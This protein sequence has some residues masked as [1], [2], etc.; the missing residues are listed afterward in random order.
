MDNTHAKYRKSVYF[1]ISGQAAGLFLAFLAAIMFA[2]PTDR[3]VFFE[4]WIKNVDIA[5]AIVGILGALVFGISKIFR[6]AYL[7]EI[8]K[9]DVM[10]NR[11]LDERKLSG[12]AE[13]DDF[14]AKL[15]EAR[16]F[17]ALRSRTG[18]IFH[19]LASIVILI[20]IGACLVTAVW[21]YLDEGSNPLTW[22]IV[23]FAVF[24]TLGFIRHIMDRP[25]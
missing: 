18:K 12:Q 15:S 20:M 8:D 14:I 11:E 19:L 6:R 9:L 3:S 13:D 24:A 21:F 4:V 16:S 10:L 23:G 2:T 5:P 25:R 22:G 7:Q 1:S 17:R